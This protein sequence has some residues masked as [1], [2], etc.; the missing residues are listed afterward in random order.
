MLALQKLRLALTHAEESLRRVSRIIEIALC[1]RTLKHRC[2]L[3]AG[4]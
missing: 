4:R 2:E 1:S 3:H